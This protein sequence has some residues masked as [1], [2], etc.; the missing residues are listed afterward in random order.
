M[1]LISNP[2]GAQGTPQANNFMQIV[3][4]A[5]STAAIT[6]NTPCLVGVGTVNSVVQLQA[7]PT[8]TGSNANFVRGVCIDAAT[9]AGQAVR[10]VIHG[11]VKGVA[12]EAGVTAGVALGRSATTAQRVDT[13]ATPN[14]GAAFA[15][16]LTA[17][18]TNT[19]DVWV[20]G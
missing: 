16:A 11:Y 8:A 6:R 4:H 18:V 1:G 9:V 7:S 17:A 5:I 19:C 12:C 10:V 15:T 3:S 14:A 2:A 13:V 20:Y